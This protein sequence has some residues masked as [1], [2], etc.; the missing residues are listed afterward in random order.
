MS[1]RNE[2]R[3]EMRIEGRKAVGVGR[4]RS[5]GD[6]SIRTHQNRSLRAQS[7]PLRLTRSS[8]DIDDLLPAIANAGNHGLVD[9][10]EEEQVVTDSFQHGAIGKAVARGRSRSHAFRSDDVLTDDRASGIGDVEHGA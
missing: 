1:A 3:L 4:D 7:G 8:N 5:E 9:L 2:V 10:A 6:E